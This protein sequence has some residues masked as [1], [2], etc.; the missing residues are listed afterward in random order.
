MSLTRQI[1]RI[2]QEIEEIESAEEWL[3]K[4]KTYELESETPSMRGPIRILEE[5]RR[6]LKAK[7]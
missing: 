3:G 7:L 6:K 2:K 4:R 1:V 5:A